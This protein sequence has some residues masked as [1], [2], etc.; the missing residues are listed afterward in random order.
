MLATLT[1]RNIMDMTTETDQKYEYM[2]LGRLQMDC[3]YFINTA[4]Y[5]KH[6]WAENT[7]DQIAK[8]RELWA[9]LKVKPEWITLEQI[10]QYAQQ[11]TSV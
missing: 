7:K 2:L 9:T 6:L 4:P 11:M 5:E 1:Q 8:M 10:D 3:E